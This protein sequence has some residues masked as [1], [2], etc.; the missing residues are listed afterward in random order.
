MKIKQ[1]FFISSL[2]LSISACNSNKIIDEHKDLS[3]NIEWEKDLVINWSVDVKDATVPYDMYLALRFISG[4]PYN[5]VKVKIETTSPSGLVDVD[6]CAIKVKDDKDL[7]L[8]DCL[9]DYCDLT[10]P[11]K[12]KNTFTEAGTYTFKASQIMPFPIITHVME[13]GLIIEKSK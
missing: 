3:P 10:V 2:I 8:G 5:D 7:L 1:I 12:M 11:F 13:L 9:G 6:T 4:I